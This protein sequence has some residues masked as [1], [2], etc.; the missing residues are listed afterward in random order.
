MKCKI[1]YNFILDQL[2][3]SLFYE[4]FQFIKNHTTADLRNV[5]FLVQHLQDKIS[6][7]EF[8]LSS[9]ATRLLN[10]ESIGMEMENSAIGIYKVISILYNLS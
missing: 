6:F 8:Y 1:N 7:E 3:L 10:E 9:L 2:I 5:S 4:L